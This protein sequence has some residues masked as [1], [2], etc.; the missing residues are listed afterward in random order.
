MEKTGASKSKAHV[1]SLH[2]LHCNNPWQGGVWAQ[3][4]HLEAVGSTHTAGTPHRPGHHTSLAKSWE[5]PEDPSPAG[6][7]LA[8]H[9]G[10]KWVNRGS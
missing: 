6:W 4:C 7:F 9:R 8:G 1:K 10:S 3:R 5:G 2:L